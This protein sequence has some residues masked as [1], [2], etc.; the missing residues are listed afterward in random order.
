MGPY[1]HHNLVLTGH[2]LT[3]QE[4]ARRSGLTPGELLESPGVL[5]LGGTTMVQE[6]YPGFQFAPR[7]LREDVAAVVQ[8]FGPRADPWEICDWLTRANSML[9]GRTPLRSLDEARRLPGVLAAIRRS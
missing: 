1:R 4:A 5:H 7:G 8:A 3:R 6:A 2:F 9:G